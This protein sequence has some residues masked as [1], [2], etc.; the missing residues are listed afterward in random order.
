M[1]EGVR[2]PLVYTPRSVNEFA[3]IIARHP[4]AV[5]WAGGTYLMSRPQYYPSEANDGII[6][7]AAMEELKRITRNDRY[8]EIGAMVTAGQL[9]SAG[10]LLLPS[11]LQQTLRS[12][13]TQIVR[14]QITVGGSLCIVGE[15][16]SLATALAILPATAEIKR[17]D[18][19]KA[20]T[21]WV[22]VSKLYDKEGMLTIADQPFL[23]TRI[24]IGLE[25][26]DFQRFLLFGDAVR[27]PLECG[28]VAF[29]AKREQ[30]GLSKAQFSVAFPRK[31]FHISR[32][33]ESKLSGVALPIHPERVNTLSYELVAELTKM[34][35]AIS[36]LQLE[37]VR[38]IFESFL[39]DLNS[40]SL[41]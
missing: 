21:H 9:L 22:A 30:N 28:I 41:S 5:I 16:L 38:R 24:R 2:S 3:T 23:L 10:R 6:D 39:H 26:G 35:H 33:L 7:L 13:G 1:L 14:R 12:L 34:H 15:R 20:T 40:Q 8:V 11:L 27:N 32:D 19:N 4:H 31:A 29:H 17:F 25:F 36:D 18:G 37:R